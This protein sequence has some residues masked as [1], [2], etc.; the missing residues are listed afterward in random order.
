MATIA[1]LGGHFAQVYGLRFQATVGGGID[2]GACVC[3]KA[4]IAR[5]AEQA[6]AYQIADIVF[7]MDAQS[8]QDNTFGSTI[9]M[10]CLCT[11]QARFQFACR[12]ARSSNQ[13]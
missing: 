2:D 10:V 12:S 9:Q 7:L 5:A 3:T 13:Y 8:G 1:L 11:V 6:I 4:E